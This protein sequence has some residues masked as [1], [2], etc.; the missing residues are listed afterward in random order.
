MLLLKQHRRR[1]YWHYIL[2]GNVAYFHTTVAE[3]V[4]SISCS[5]ISTPVGIMLQISIIIL[6]QFLL[7]SLSSLAQSYYF[8]AYDFIIILRLQVNY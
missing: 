8:C 3:T 6:F 7:K 4:K 1:F 2:F 5:P